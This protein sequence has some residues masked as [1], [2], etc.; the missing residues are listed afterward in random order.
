MRRGVD[1]VGSA[2]ARR[3]GHGA[4]AGEVERGKPAEDEDACREGEGLREPGCGPPGA[5]QP[6]GRL[7]RE[8]RAPL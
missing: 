1:L 3:G 6:G 5:G 4:P 2:G 7:S 8:R